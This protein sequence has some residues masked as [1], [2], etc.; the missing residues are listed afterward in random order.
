MSSTYVIFYHV[1]RNDKK[2]KIL[3]S[4]S[5][6]EMARRKN[7]TYRTVLSVLFSDNPHALIPPSSFAFLALVLLSHFY[8]NSSR[9]QVQFTRKDSELWTSTCACTH[10]L[11]TNT[12]FSLVAS[13]SRRN[14]KRAADRLE[15]NNVP[16]YP[17]TQHIPQKKQQS[18]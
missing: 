7:C 9:T 14:K 4:N 10:S 2:K 5:R 8:H 3:G 18:E 13:W 1:R 16:P 15:K 11:D 6:R 17:Y 12:L